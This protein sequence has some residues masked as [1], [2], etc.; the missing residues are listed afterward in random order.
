MCTLINY[1]VEHHGLVDDGPST[2][3]VSKIHR[4]RTYRVVL[5]FLAILSLLWIVGGIIAIVARPYRR[6]YYRSELDGLGISTLITCVVGALV[7]VLLTGIILGQ[8]LCIGF[9]EPIYRRGGIALSEES[10]A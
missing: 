5:I 6:G 4:R 2:G 3:L 10:A 8:A 7:T 9:D 1:A